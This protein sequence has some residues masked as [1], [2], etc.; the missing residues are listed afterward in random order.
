MI[1]KT[2]EPKT[3]PVVFK[4]NLKFKPVFFGAKKMNKGG[5]VGFDPARFKTQH[6]G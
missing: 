4:P 1:K 3:N 2:V 5:A 6:K